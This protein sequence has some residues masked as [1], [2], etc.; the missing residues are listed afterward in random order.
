[1]KSSVVA[2]AL[3]EGD[4]MAHE[5][6]ETGALVVGRAVAQVALVVDVAL[7]AIGGGLAST[8]ISPAVTTLD[9]SVGP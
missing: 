4:A 5:L 3:A 7:V 1:M 6:V 8:A 9:A 2:T